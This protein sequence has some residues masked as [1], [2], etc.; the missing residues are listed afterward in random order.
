[1]RHMS[2][3]RLIR[4]PARHSKPARP[5]RA[6]PALALSLAL[7]LAFGVGPP[8]S[9]AQSSRPSDAPASAREARDRASA[10]RAAHCGP[11]A[12][13]LARRGVR[14]DAAGFVRHC[15]CEAREF[16]RL[17]ADDELFPAVPADSEEQRRRNRLFAARLQERSEAAS[18]ACGP[19]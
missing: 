16:Y 12:E 5:A 1:M 19:R 2:F 9:L 3:S 7:A 18:R 11:A 10:Q 14:F 15:E 4:V 8:Q 17:V 6:A 13:D